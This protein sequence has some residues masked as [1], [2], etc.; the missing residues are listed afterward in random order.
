MKNNY[1]IYVLLIAVPLLVYYGSFHHEFVRFDDDLQ[2][3]NNPFVIDFNVDNL[4][5]IFTTPVLGMYAPFTGLMYAIVAS[6]FGVKSAYAFHLF[7]F[8][9]H[10]VNLLFVYLIGCKL[11]KNTTK[12]VFLT[13]LFSIHPLA[14]EVVGWVSATSTV[15]FSLFFLSGMYFYIRYLES[16]KHI[17]YIYTLVLFVFGC[18]SKVQIIPFVGVLFLLDI[19]FKPGWFSRKGILEKIPFIIISF[20]FLAIALSFRQNEKIVNASNYSSFYF[21]MNQISWYLY[22]IFA[23]FSIG[24]SYVW[25]KQ[26]LIQHHVA[27]LAVLPF[28]YLVY[29]FRNNK[30]FVFGILFFLANIILHTALFSVTVSSYAGRYAYLSSIGVW[31]ALMSL[32]KK[33]HLQYMIPVFIVVFL[34]L[35][36]KQLKI[37]KNSKALYEHA[38]QFET[39][40]IIYYNLGTFYVY[41]EPKKAIRYFL[42]SVELDPDF[43][44]GYYNLGSMIIKTNPKKAKSYFLKTIKLKPDHVRAMNQLGT[45]YLKSN[46]EKAKEYFLKAVSINPTYDLSYINL[47]VLSM[48]SNSEKAISYFNKAISVNPQSDNAFNNLGVLYMKTNLEKAKSYFQKAIQINPKQHDYYLNLG[49]VFLKQSDNK[50]AE[51]LFIKT[52]QLSPNNNKATKLLKRV[53]N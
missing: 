51:Q 41:S 47:G 42:K 13:L 32:V 6:F 44:R 45:L 25:P 29:Y 35:S 4:K 37:W 18:L 43:Y 50:K 17:F 19:L 34:F 22:K 48:Q 21:S 16:R 3:Y 24:I 36:K 10:I 33:R 15:L 5:N 39:T 52:L 30:L 12:A 23:P 40:S 49:I 11:F 46:P 7:S 26:L 27:A 38:I 1:F 8:I 9:I 31:I 20:I 53:R 2:V 14:V 28:G